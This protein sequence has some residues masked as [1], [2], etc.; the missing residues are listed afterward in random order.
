MTISSACSALTNSRTFE[1]SNT[2]GRVTRALGNEQGIDYITGMK[3]RDMDEE[4]EAPAA[5]VGE[6]IDPQQVRKKK[7]KKKGVGN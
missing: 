4:D 6:M 3:E 2:I 7:K 1:L 5:P